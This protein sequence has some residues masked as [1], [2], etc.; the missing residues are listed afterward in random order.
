[1]RAAAPFFDNARKSL[2]SRQLLVANFRLERQDGRDAIGED[3]E[4]GAASA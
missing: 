3:A 2:D 4:P 1:M